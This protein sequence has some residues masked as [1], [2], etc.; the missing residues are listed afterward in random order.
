[1]RRDVNVAMLL[2]NEFV[3]DK[4]VYREAKALVNADF[5]LT[6]YAVRRRD[7]QDDEVK[8]GIRVKRIFSQALFDVKQPGYMR[9]MAEK[10]AATE[11][12]VVHCHDSR[13]LHV[14]VSIK[15]MRPQTTLIYDSHE[16]FHSWPIHYDSLRPDV[17]LKTWLVRQLEIRREKSDSRFIDHLITVSGSIAEHLKERFA[18][19]NEPVLVRNMAEYEEITE[20][21]DFVRQAF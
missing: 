4:R 5:N 12:D 14:G 11:P 10:I 19:R 2:D 6:L 3:L 13:M 15:R 16:L 1:M 8:D 7:L 9:A 21:K 17:V 20:R 18:L